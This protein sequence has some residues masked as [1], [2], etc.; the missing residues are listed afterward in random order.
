MLLR[1]VNILK[2][3]IDEAAVNS[4]VEVMEQNADQPENVRIYVAGMG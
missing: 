2:I 4:I 1:M 3:T